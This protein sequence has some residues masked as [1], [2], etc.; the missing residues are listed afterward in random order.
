MTPWASDTLMGQMCWVMKELFGEELLEEFIFYLEEDIPPFIVSAGFPGDLLPKPLLP[1]RRERSLTLDEI[2]RRKEVK[3]VDYITRERFNRALTQG[4]LDEVHLLPSPFKVT[5]NLHASIGRNTGTT[6][7]EG[8]L[9]SLD[10][11]FLSDEYGYISLYALVAPDWYDIFTESIEY[12]GHI[13]FGK[14]KSSGKGRFLVQS[15]EGFDG[16]T[17]PE[18]PDGFVVLSHYLPAKTDPMDGRYHVTIRHGKL[19]EDR[20]QWSNPFKRPVILISPGATF[21]EENPSP[22]YGRMTRGVHES[23]EILTF[24][25]GIAIPCKIYKSQK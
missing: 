6:S 23:E 4:V 18:E 16:F 24:G 22:Y 12:M 9:Y 3:K 2:Q 19:G 15:I 14:K 20:A 25:F 1:Q 11:Y 21:K 8:G 7:G 17:I 5:T 13:G 10:E